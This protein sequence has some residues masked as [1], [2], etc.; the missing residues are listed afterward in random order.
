ML[1]ADTIAKIRWAFFVEKKPI[2]AICRE[3]KRSRTA[4]RRAIRSGANAE[5]PKQKRTAYRAAEIGK[6]FIKN[7]EPKSRVTPRVLDATF[8]ADF[9]REGHLLA[10]IILALVGQAVDCAVS[11]N[12]FLI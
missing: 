3:L 7:A 1:T 11:N 9:P 8:S 5:R 10:L 12:E 4:V 6:Q 2:K